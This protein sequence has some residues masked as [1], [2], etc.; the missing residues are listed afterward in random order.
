MG[1]NHKS[2]RSGVVAFDTAGRR[3][4][5][6]FLLLF[7]V[8]LVVLAGGVAVVSSL[9]NEAPRHLCFFTAESVALVAHL[10]DSDAV[11]TAN[12]VSTEGFSI[13]VIGECTGLTEIIIFIAAIAA[14][15][16]TLV[17]KL[18]GIVLGT[19]VILATNIIRMVTLLWIGAS[20]QYWFSICHYY[21]YQASMLLLVIGA[22]ILWLHYVALRPKMRAAVV[23][24]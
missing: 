1:Q 12:Q 17:R 3:Q 13:E 4:I 18:L 9:Y 7:L 21:T 11:C 20:S 16:S 8:I 24:G 19:V 5:F 22:F 6:K 2:R 14:F 10:F 23:S 15:P